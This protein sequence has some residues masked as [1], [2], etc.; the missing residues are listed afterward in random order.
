MRY[1]NYTKDELIQA[2]QT[3][4]SYAE[5]LRKIGLIP[6]GGNYATIRKAIKQYNLDT[7]HM[8]GQL[9]SKGRIIGPKVPITEYLT[10][11]KSINTHNLR[12]RLLHEK[13]FKPKCQNCF[14]ET[15]QGKPIPLELHH[16][17][18]NRLNNNLKNLNLLCPNCH[19]QTDNYRGKNIGAPSR[20]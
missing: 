16:I 18:G 4:N 9:W 1:L 12:L 17:D 5:A 15:W 8:T 19:S 13:Y 3:S 10:N 2:I 7:T 14:N 11:S 20:T 6:I